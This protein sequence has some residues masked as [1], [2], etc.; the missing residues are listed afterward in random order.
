MAQNPE[1]QALL[2]QALRHVLESQSKLLSHPQAEKFLEG[3][4]AMAELA[5][6]TWETIG[7][8]FHRIDRTS[9]LT[10][11]A[12]KCELI[13][14][15]ASE[16]NWIAMPISVSSIYERVEATFSLRPIQEKLKLKAALD[17][18]NHFHN[19]RVGLLGQL[20]NARMLINN[21]DYGGELQKVWQGF[22]QNQLGPNFRVLEGGHIMDHSGN[23]ANA[24]IDLIVVPSDAQVMTASGSEGAKANVLC[25]QVIA[26]IMVT[27][28]LKK[29]KIREDWEKLERISGLFSYRDGLLQ[30]KAPAWPLCYLVAG[31]SDSLDKLKNAW[32]T[33]VAQSPQSQFVP[34]FLLS[35]D[36]GYMY[37][38]ATS[39]PRPR[40]PGNYTQRD[41]I[42]HE[43]GIHSG[44]GLAWLLTQIRSRAA[45]LQ[46]RS[47][48]SI[49]RFTKLLDDATLKEATPPTWSNRFD[50]MFKSTPV[51]GGL[52]W[53]RQ[54]RFG[55]N[56]LHLVTLEKRLPD[57]HPV[58]DTNYY[59][60]TE[61]PLPP[62]PED[63]E[64]LLRWFRHGEYRVSGKLV[65]LE[66]WT[67]T[68]GDVPLVRSFAVFDS[69]SG[70]EIPHPTGRTVPTT[71]E[72]ALRAV[73]A[74]T[75]D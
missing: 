18:R 20:L 28:V 62:K 56:R 51:H 41:E 7:E 1:T 46:S 14:D 13:I 54:A 72:E 32:Q 70:T 26:A 69:E 53:G 64:S 65:A 36:S 12:R 42:A 73:S 22:L 24:Q 40:Y 75:S 47:D 49:H 61:Q 44:L 6:A 31:Q 17:L 37:S 8:G 50:T 5:S 27:S 25:D 3:A 30:S 11:L 45:L 74:L 63:R 59:R 67:R 38:G 9:H 23:N 43:A 34:Q 52:K 71:I 4:Q 68:E 16:R 57:D 66:E 29:A 55:H 19:L 60:T 58:T 39:H 48:F 21:S 10:A 35:L 15:D 2:E 33:Q